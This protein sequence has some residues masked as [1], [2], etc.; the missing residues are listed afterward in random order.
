MSMQRPPR[1]RK[2]LHRQD[3]LGPLAWWLGLGSLALATGLLPV[4][5]MLLGWSVPFWLL[6][7][8]L[9]LMVVVAPELPGQWLD[10]L[11]PNRLAVRERIWN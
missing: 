3:L 11:R 9:L 6:L 1:A 5:S 2:A 4:H 7:T 10:R 8:P